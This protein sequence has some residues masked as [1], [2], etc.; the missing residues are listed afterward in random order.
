MRVP[1]SPH[2]HQLSVFQ[3]FVFA[4]IMGVKW[5]PTVVS[6]GIFLIAGEG[7]HLLQKFIDHWVS[8]SVNCLS[9]SFAYILLNC[10]S[11]PLWLLRLCIFWMWNLCVKCDLQPK[12]LLTGSGWGFKNIW[13]KSLRG[14]NILKERE[15]PPK[16][17][18]YLLTSLKDFFPQVLESDRQ[19]CKI[20]RELLR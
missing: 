16:A 15:R 13:I 11:S 10:F 8:S 5:Y 9:I 17:R 14:T 1:V 2:P 3:I 20:Q 4:N 12:S 19:V 18:R 7:K 6:I